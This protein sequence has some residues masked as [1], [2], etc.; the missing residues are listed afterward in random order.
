MHT[1]KSNLYR[2]EVI[3]PTVLTEIIYTFNCYINNLAF[4]KPSKKEKKEVRVEN[5]EPRCTLLENSSTK[6][7]LKL[8]KFVPFLI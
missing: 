8:S 7:F 6:K 2:T 5:K 1:Q 3:L 4:S